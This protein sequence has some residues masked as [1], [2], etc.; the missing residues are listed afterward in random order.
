M[1][2]YE[3][4]SCLFLTEIQAEGIEPDYNNLFFDNSLMF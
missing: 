2:I 4:K 1:V 3:Y